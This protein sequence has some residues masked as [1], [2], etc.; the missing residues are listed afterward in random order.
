M[1]GDEH[2]SGYRGGQIEYNFI[3]VRFIYFQLI[4]LTSL[5]FA[6]IRVTRRTQTTAPSNCLCTQRWVLYGDEENSLHAQFHVSAGDLKSDVDV[7]FKTLCSHAAGGV[8]SLTQAQCTIHTT[9]IRCHTYST[10]S[11]AVTTL[12]NSLLCVYVKDWNEH[13]VH[14][15]YARP[16]IGGWNAP[17]EP[18]KQHCTLPLRRQYHVTLG[19]LYTCKH[20][21]Y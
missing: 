21:K 8:A 2:K 5:L 3:W 20:V 14:W 13:N 12:M 11:R 19:L 18:S 4:C 9:P 15:T 10:M 17:N 1:A 6:N 7:V 16:P